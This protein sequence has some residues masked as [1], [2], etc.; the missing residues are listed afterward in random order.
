LKESIQVPPTHVRKISPREFDPYLKSIEHVIDKYSLNKQMGF[1]TGMAFVL[2]KDQLDT[3]L[4][5]VESLITKY[6]LNSKQG[7]VAKAR[8]LPANVPPR[9]VVPATFKDPNFNLSNPHIFSA[10]TDFKD[11]IGL[12]ASDVLS[13]RKEI[14]DKLK[15]YSE[16]IEIYLL[17][18]ISLRSTSFFEALSY[19]KTLQIEAQSCGD[20]IGKLKIRIENLSKAIS[21]KGLEVVKLTR[22]RG[23][24][25]VL[26]NAVQLY[27]QLKQT[28]PLIQ[29]M[30]SQADY[31]GALDLLDAGC[32]TITGQN[33]FAVNESVGRIETVSKGYT[34]LISRIT[35]VSCKTF[36]SKNFNIENVTSASGIIKSICDMQYETEFAMK[37]EYINILSADLEETVKDL[38]EKS[39]KLPTTI[40]SST[41]GL[42]LMFAN[43]KLMKWVRF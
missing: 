16:I 17:K 41:N 38:I 30:I 23:N 4:I 27:S 6:S 25:A 39:I 33:K 9:D 31:V 21:K 1:E 20:K 28:Q 7:K 8:M 43:E 5:G 32:V 19:L 11:V 14:Q 29:L 36:L 42:T 3:D 22:R 37:D 15:Y 18:E 13:I 40:E 2:F 34:L 24:V 26:T 12:S 10:V 35:I